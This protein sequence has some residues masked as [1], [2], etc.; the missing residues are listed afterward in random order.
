MKKIAKISIISP[1][2]QNESQIGKFIESM[3]KE[4]IFPLQR[5]RIKTEMIVAEDGSTDNTR[6][7]LK[8]LEKKYRLKLLLAKKR[9]GPVRAI[10]N[11]FAQARGDLIFFLDADGE[12]EP[13]S[14]WSLY[15]VFFKEDC[16]LV[17]AHKLKRKPWY[18]FLISRFNNLLL[19][20]LFQTKIKDANAGCRLYKADI[21]KR[22]VAQ[23]GF[24]KYNF[25]SEQIILATRSH[26]KIGEVGVPHFERES[27]AFKT[28]KLIQILFLATIELYRFKYYLVR[29]K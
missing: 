6:H 28:T 25:N 20:I 21:A 1:A 17:V 29:Q 12:V 7:I 5:M 18:R 11:L 23:C 27:V 2:H 3:F 4:V 22:I 24:L 16:D 13:Q 9:L 10:K 14:F 26:L 19:R 8:S 15:K